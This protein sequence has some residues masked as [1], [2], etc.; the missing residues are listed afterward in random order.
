VKARSWPLFAIGALFAGPFVVALLLY[1]GRGSFGGFE[2]LPNPDRELFASP[3]GIPLAPLRLADGSA[4]DPGW[5]RSRWSLIYARMRPCE[6]SCLDA[7]GR[8]H[9]VYLALGSE[10]DRVRL[11][12][13]VPA[14]AG[15]TRV[16]ADFLLGILAAP[17][18]D[19]LVR[20]FGPERLEEGRY[21]VVDP[22]GNVILSYPDDADQG[23]LL[24][25]LERLLEFSRVG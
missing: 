15:S 2:Q 11:V 17:G 20:V 22:L 25:D 4:T 23:R 13:L 5:A 8:L 14:S 16:P 9:E 12:L 21:F 6:A 18:G 7:L 3:P 1:A 19:E 10:R 24:Q